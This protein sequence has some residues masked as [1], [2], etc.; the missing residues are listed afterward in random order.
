MLWGQLRVAAMWPKVALTASVRVSTPSRGS[1]FWKLC[2]AA[3]KY[4][5]TTSA[6]AGCQAWETPVFQVSASW[7]VQL[8]A[9]CAAARMAS[10]MGVLLSRVGHL[11]WKA[12]LSVSGWRGG[13]AAEATFRR[14]VRAMSPAT[15]SILVF[16]LVLL[17]I[18]LLGCYCCVLGQ[19]TVGV[20]LDG[21]F[22]RVTL[23]RVGPFIVQENFISSKIQYLCKADLNLSLRHWLTGMYLEACGPKG[24]SAYVFLASCRTLL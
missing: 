16:M 20:F 19:S 21:C 8:L 2:L 6:T 13:C 18:Y 4:S 3:L 11:A 23:G 22:G 14:A 15:F 7:L 10:F 5:S 24:E 9:A 1:P 12:S 17:F